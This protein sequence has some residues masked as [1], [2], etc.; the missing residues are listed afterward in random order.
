MFDVFDLRRQPLMRFWMGLA[1]AMLL[2]SGLSGADRPKKPL[3]ETATLPTDKNVLK[4]FG[5]IEEYLSDKRWVEAIE[6]LQEIA[7]SDGRMLVLAQPGSAGEYAVYLNVAARCNILLSQLPAEGLALYRKKIDPQARR[8]LDRWK[9]SH[10]EGNLQRIIREAYLSSYGDDALWELGEAA[11]DRGDIG[12]A[13]LYWTQLIPL[14]Q[15]ANTQKLPTVLRYPDSDLKTPEILVRLILCTLMEGNHDRATQELQR[16]AELFPEAQGSLAGRQGRLADLAAQVLAES[17]QWKSPDD[18]GDTSTF[19]IN[20]HRS[21]KAPEAIELGASKWS[22][23]LPSNTLPPFDRPNAP[24]DR[25]PLSYYPVTYR[26]VVLVNNSRSIWAWNLLTGEPAWPSEQGHAEIYSTV[27]EGNA[28]TPNQ[29]CAGVP[30]Y[31]MTVADGKLYARMGSPV[32][33]PT[34]NE[35]SSEASENDLICLDLANGQGKLLWKIGAN[36]LI[37]ED[38]KQWR[39]EGS[40]LVMA[41]RAYVALSRRRTQ[42]EFAIAC[43]DATTGALLWYRNVAS[44]RSSVEDYQ[45]RVSHLLLTAGAGKLFLST[46]AGTIIAVNAKDGQLEWAITYESLAPARP[47]LLSSHFYQGLLP[48]IF[49]EGFVFVAPN[50]CNRLF[51]IEADSGRVRWQHRQPESDRWRHL[52]GVSP[53]GDAGRL[54]LSGNTLWAID[55][56][57]NKTIFGS[58]ANTLGIRGPSVEQGYGRGIIAGDVILW[59]TR[60]AIKIVD[61]KT[62]SV[63]GNKPL[64]T[65]TSSDVAGNLVLCQEMLLVAQPERLVAY[66]EYS[67]LKQRLE[68]ELSER[69]NAN[70]NPAISQTG[71]TSAGNRI[72]HES[73]ESLLG[74]LAEIEAA[75]GNRIASADSLRKAVK[76]SEST[77]RL[78]DASKLPYRRRLLDLLR[79]MAR[80]AIDDGHASVA[81]EHLTEAQTLSN[82]PADTVATLLMMADAE[83]AQSL[84]VAAVAHWQKILDSEP[85]RTMPMKQSTAGAMAT[86][87]IADLIRERG[88]A[89]YADVERQANHEIAAR[90]QANDLDG[91]GDALRRYPNAEA[92]SQAWRALATLNRRAGRINDAL[93]IQARLLEEPGSPESHGAALLDWAETLEQAG[94]WRSA[95]AAWTQL[96]SPPLSKVEIESEGS[97]HQLGDVARERLSGDT[98]K[99]ATAETAATKRPLERIWAIPL[100]S[101]PPV[102]EKPPQP[103][104]ELDA[105]EVLSP[106]SIAPAAPLE[107]VLVR[108]ADDAGCAWQCVDRQTGKVRWRTTLSA[109]PWWSAYSETSLLLAIEDQLVALTLESGSPLWTTSLIPPT[110]Q[111]ERRAGPSAAPATSDQRVHS[112]QICLRNHWALVFDPQTGVMA[113][114]ARTGRIAW[115]FQPPRGKLQSQ[116]A[117][118]EWH[119]AVQTLHPAT[120]W[121]IDV[122][123][124][125][126]ASDRPGS[127]EPWLQG[128]VFTDNDALIVLGVDRRIESRSLLN[129]QRSWRYQGGMS[130]AYVNPVVWMSGSTLLTI[131]DGTTLARIDLLTGRPVWTAGIADAPLTSPAR[132]IVCSGDAAY[133]ASQGILRQISLTNGKCL[134]QRYLG[135]ITDQWR[136]AICDDL[137]AAWPMSTETQGP[138]PR[139]RARQSIV[140]CE[141]P[142]GRIV[143]TTAFDSGEHIVNLT[144]NDSGCLVQTSQKLIALRDSPPK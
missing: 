109:I 73:T 105:T 53:G 89:V 8:W 143:Q 129:G 43:V 2:I 42:L 140:W 125:C 122:A 118:T 74:Q 88:R 13:R 60:E 35:T 38:Q 139:E 24:H 95:K 21:G 57:T 120:T 137:I 51:C 45:N 28:S 19:G 121:F 10:D 94:Y 116:W 44:A 110:D 85:L 7:Q 104:A 132:Q 134:W 46:D 58:R 111:S 61:V 133:I 15:E 92:T 29:S 106:E 75:E 96:E 32:T 90:Q 70:G 34:D 123:A 54:I 117:C 135:S 5:A 126:R 98:I 12:S 55:I 52:L 65:P 63:T 141:L 144:T 130:F 79:Q 56:A 30:Y 113:I 49:H 47:H 76:A 14:T 3:R 142:T 97:R 11:W 18:K 114:D 67:L 31:T 33:N 27:A 81:I 4:R 128:P 69:A 41:G 127:V 9:Q 77:A 101:R 86:K 22:H 6:I 138:A 112:A 64:H 1:L 103:P 26:D 20:V 23:V 124:R 37:K 39:F 84:P 100:R 50:D 83:L 68:R 91:L 108:C 115:T 78:D 16:F 59:P 36:E 93:A 119:I 40:P 71:Q 131:V 80:T 62:G 107:C 136:L 66:C 102:N 87:L 82:E 99:S 72:K 25:G 48:A 17:A